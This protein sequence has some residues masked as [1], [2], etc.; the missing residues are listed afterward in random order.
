MVNRLSLFYDWE[1][2]CVQYALLC[3][4]CSFWCMTIPTP[5]PTSISLFCL[6]RSCDYKQGHNFLRSL[7]HRADRLREF[8]PLKEL[9][10][11]GPAWLQ[12]RG[13]KK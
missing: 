1:E 7:L 13:R 12:G 8:T 9:C 10:G 6:R 3:V 5:V 2:L 11:I 4:V